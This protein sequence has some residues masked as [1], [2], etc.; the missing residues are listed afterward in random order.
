MNVERTLTARQ[1]RYLYSIAL[2]LADGGN[3]VKVRGIARKV[4]GAIRSRQRHAA[5]ART[6]ERREMRRVAD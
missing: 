5:R 2:V 1:I 6:A 3:V 4:V